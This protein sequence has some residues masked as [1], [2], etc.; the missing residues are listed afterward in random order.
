METIILPL[1]LIVINPE[2]A[3]AFPPMPGKEYQLLKD[4][5]RLSGMHTP[6]HRLSNHTTPTRRGT[7]LYRISRT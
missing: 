3:G 5:I 6:H 7:N 2:Y 1:S 4:N